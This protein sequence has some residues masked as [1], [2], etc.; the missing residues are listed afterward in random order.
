MK[1]EEPNM[2]VIKLMYSDIVTL[3]NGGNGDD[4]GYGGPWE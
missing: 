1:Y 4:D 3:S 2:E